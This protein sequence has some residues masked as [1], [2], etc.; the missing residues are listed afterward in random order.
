MSRVFDHPNL[1]LDWVCPICRTNA[2]IP[3]ILVPIKQID[4]WNAEAEQVHLKC[5]AL[6]AETA[7]EAIKDT[8]R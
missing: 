5:A 2:D 4:E 6:V 7:R 1:S 3:V 8:G